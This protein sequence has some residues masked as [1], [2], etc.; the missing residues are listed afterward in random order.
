MCNLSGLAV[1]DVGVYDVGG[2]ELVRLRAVWVG[3][4]VGDAP[5]AD[6]GAGSGEGDSLSAD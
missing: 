5:F 2:F 3:L 1:L 6:A 4:G